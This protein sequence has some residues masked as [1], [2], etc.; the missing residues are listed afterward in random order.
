MA[1]VAD[2][3]SP[4]P[5]PRV[6]ATT[7]KTPP[8]ETAEDLAVMLDELWRFVDD[9]GRDRGSIDVAFSPPALGDPAA[10][11]GADGTLE[12]IAELAAIGVTWT[13]LAVP[14]DSLAHALEA[15]EELGDTVIARSVR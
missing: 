5:A 2:G 7:A 14:G 1:A 15:L 11:G 8:L 12:T 13:S 4:F 9:A 10:G 3:W 6:L